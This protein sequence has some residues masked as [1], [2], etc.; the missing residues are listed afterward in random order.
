MPQTSSAALLIW[1]GGELAL[2]VCMWWC[3]THPWPASAPATWGALR[4]P[5][6]LK[7]WRRMNRRVRVGP[8]G[9]LPR[10][11]LLLAPRGRS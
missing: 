5:P 10:G 1:L 9:S 2:L 8:I 4:L 7:E 11:N 3:Q 6:H